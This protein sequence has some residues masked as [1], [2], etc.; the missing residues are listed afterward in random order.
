MNRA[1]RAVPTDKHFILC[2]AVRTRG[3]PRFRSFAFPNCVLANG[4]TPKSHCFLELISMHHPA[5]RRTANACSFLQGGR[6]NRIRTDAIGTSGL[7]I[8]STIAGAIRRNSA[9]QSTRPRMIQTRQSQPMGRCILRRIATV[10][11]GISTFTARI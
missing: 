5:S 8:R 2:G 6:R 4:V 3:R 11:P 10:L 7:S 9:S 1:D